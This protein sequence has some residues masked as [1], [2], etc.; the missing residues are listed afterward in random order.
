MANSVLTFPNCDKA[1][2]K[3]ARF[4]YDTA[5]ASLD[6]ADHATSEGLNMVTVSRTYLKV[7]PDSL[8]RS[9]GDKAVSTGEDEVHPEH[10][11]AVEHVSVDATDDLVPRVC[12]QSQ[13]GCK[14][15]TAGC[16]L[17]NWSTWLKAGIEHS[18]TR[19][20]TSAHVTC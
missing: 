7:Q 20:K 10:G 11:A 2:S 6:M 8:A 15:P 19:I 4:R 3:G 5:A 14:T 9:L 1:H 13:G 18:A 12:T 17:G 16:Q